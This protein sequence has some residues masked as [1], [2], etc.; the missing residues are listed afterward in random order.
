[1]QEQTSEEKKNKT[2][3]HLSQDFK[4][5]RCYFLKKK[6]EDYSLEL[7]QQQHHFL[8]NSDIQKGVRNEHI[9]VFTFYV[10]NF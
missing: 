7:N 2:F 6:K 3:R 5:K 1:M 10:F 8:K 4:W 9:L